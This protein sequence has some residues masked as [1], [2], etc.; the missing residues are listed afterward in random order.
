M[1]KEIGI[2]TG[3]ILLSFLMA[4]LQGC[5]VR[6]VSPTDEEL[7]NNYMLTLPG[8]WELTKFDVKITENIGTE[9]RPVFLSKFQAQ[10]RL[11]NPT[12]IKNKDSLRKYLMF[13]R[14]LRQNYN[15][16]FLKPAGQVGDTVTIYG[17][18]VTKRHRGTWNIEFKLE[19]DPISD[20]G[21]PAN[22]FKGEVKIFEESDEEKAL[23]AGLE[24]KVEA[25][26]KKQRDLEEDRLGK[27]KQRRD[28]ENEKYRKNLVEEKKRQK[29]QRI[30]NLIEEPK[31]YKFGKE[32]KLE[33]EKQVDNLYPTNKLTRSP[34][35][36]K[37]SLVS[38]KDLNYKYSDIHS[39]GST[40]SES[41]AENFFLRVLFINAT[42]SSFNNIYICVQHFIVDKP[43]TISHGGNVRRSYSKDKNKL[44]VKKIYRLE[45][46]LPNQKLVIDTKGINLRFSKYQFV[47][48]AYDRSHAGLDDTYRSFSGEEYSGYIISI[49]HKRKLLFQRTSNRNLKEKGVEKLSIKGQIIND[50]LFKD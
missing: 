18:A 23:F 47:D 39:S 22:Y 14:R 44:Y 15:M 7:K 25:E 5:G 19:N 37:S 30:R 8:F 31:V 17:R 13:G 21:E 50:N 32:P 38:F 49:F 35:L 46:I 41:G 20:L 2:L 12:F 29:K 24:D 40:K 27:E 48:D 3:F 11:K 42:Q 36:V 4:A 45:K 26:K 9:I 34:F 43:Y 33:K 28:L 10:V 16:V 6:D 1:K